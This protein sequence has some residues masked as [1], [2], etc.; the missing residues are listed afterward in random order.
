MQS[1]CDDL[2]QCGQALSAEQM[3]GAWMEQQEQSELWRNV[4][5]FFAFQMQQAMVKSE[6]I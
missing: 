2:H 6:K 5:P 4:P 3:A 1:S